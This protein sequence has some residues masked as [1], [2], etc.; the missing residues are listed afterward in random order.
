[1]KEIHVVCAVIIHEGKVLATKRGYGE[2]IHNWEFPGGKIEKGEDAGK[3]LIREIK[4]ELNADIKVDTK[5]TDITYDYPQFRLHMAAYACHL[6]SAFTLLEHEDY[7]W[8]NLLNL[9][10]V[11]WLP[12]DEILLNKVEEI[13]KKGT[14]MSTKQEYESLNGKYRDESHIFQSIEIDDSLIDNVN[15]QEAITIFNE[16]EDSIIYFGAN[17]CPWCRNAL[18]V[19]IKYAKKH[20]KRI[21]YVNMDQKRPKYIHND[22]ND[23]ILEYP[24]DKDYHLLVENFIKIMRPCV[25]K[26]SGEEVPNTYNIPLPLV[27]F[28]NQGKILFHHYGTVELNDGQTP[29]DLLDDKQEEALLHIYENGIKA[30][31]HVCDG[32]NCLL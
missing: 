25:I 31:S 15:I 23:I 11:K 21:T 3:A 30:S 5:I 24:G 20:N 9:Y 32:D 13:L 4:E 28:G 16:K 1:M 10:S 7:K 29:Y 26:P 14:F 6:L 27:V 19:L 17:W 12:A 18:P 22:N 8:L 2:F